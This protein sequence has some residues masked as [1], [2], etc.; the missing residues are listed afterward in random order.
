[1]AKLAQNNKK[2]RSLEKEILSMVSHDLKSPLNG[3]IGFSQ[4]LSEELKE[5]NI[6]P[7][8]IEMVE[9]I[10]NAGRQMYRL[11]DNILTTYKIAS[12]KE[13][14]NFQEVFNVEDEIQKVIQTF[15][16]ESKAKQITISINQKN[17]MPIV[18]W[19]IE[20]LRFHVF[21]NLLSNAL[22]YTPKG[23]F[24]NIDIER[25]N[26][27]IYFTIE[28]TGCGIPEEIIKEIFG[29]YYQ[30]NDKNNEPGHGVGLYNA[31]IFVESHGGK[32]WA[33]NNYE[34]SNGIKKPVGAR[35]IIELPVIAERRKEINSFSI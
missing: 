19:D 6:S 21:N 32:I 34:N 16:I 13:E 26:K 9:Y 20:R 7:E 22:K 27:N 17:I 3:I 30:P 29:F 28:D 33:E 12:G 11:V 24:I 4:I 15:E 18:K 35:F 8:T 10:H 31:R 2:N 25:K 5:K 23:G 1:M 14:P